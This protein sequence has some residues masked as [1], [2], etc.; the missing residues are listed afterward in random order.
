ML[1]LYQETPVIENGMLVLPDKPGLGLT[2]DEKAIASF[3]V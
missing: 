3:K 1:C 2:F